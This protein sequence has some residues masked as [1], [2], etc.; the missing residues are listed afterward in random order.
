MT[1]WSCTVYLQFVCYVSVKRVQV[2]VCVRALFLK[3]VGSWG[4]GASAVYSVFM[5]DLDS[6]GQE[7]SAGRLPGQD[8]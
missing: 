3:G 7:D 2:Y 8:W 6:R 5:A 1:R 4:G